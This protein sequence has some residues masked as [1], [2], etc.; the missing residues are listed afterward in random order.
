M[1]LDFDKNHGLIPAVIQDVETAKVLMLGFMSE[2]AYKITRDTKKVTFFSRTRNRIWTKGETSG[3]FMI[4]KEIIPDCDR[5]TIL[6]KVKPTGPVCHTG[7]DTC[8]DEENKDQED[9]IKYLSKVI[10]GRKKMPK[11]GSYT[12]MLFEKGINKIAQKVG[13]EAVELVIESKD[14]NKELFLNEAADLFFHY[15]VL[16]E[17]KGYS[18]DDIIEVLKE[19]HK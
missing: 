17:A 9:F 14:D 12:S 13:E 15:M 10:A 2:E 19:R 18:F 8:F 11:E 4:V 16:L 6:I 5:D 1:E 7:A 3:N